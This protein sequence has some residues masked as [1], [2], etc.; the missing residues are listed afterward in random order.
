M[1]CWFSHEAAHKITYGESELRPTSVQSEGKANGLT[2]IISDED[3][4]N[5][6]IIHFNSVHELSH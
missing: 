1:H 6:S 4:T 3:Y 5:R 2:S